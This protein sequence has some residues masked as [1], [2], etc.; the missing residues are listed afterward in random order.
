[1]K[2]EGE[3]AYEPDML[4]LM[5]RF[6]EVLGDDKKVWREAT[7]IKDRS[8]LIDGKT[9]KNPTF[10]NFE[11]VIDVLLLDPSKMQAEEETDSTGLFKTEEDKYEYKRRKEI[12]L[13]EIEGE[14]TKVW[15]STGAGDKQK[16]L[17]ALDAVFGTRSWTAVTA[18]GIDALETG[19][20][21]IRELV[22]DELAKVFPDVAKKQK[23]N[24][25]AK[26]LTKK[27]EDNA[28]AFKEGLK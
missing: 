12:A 23:E 28:K 17:D 18:L 9:F 11:P 24:K 4:V 13:E 14:L 5:E 6:E 19:L 21:G 25:Q 7:V 2:V 1:M 15:P 8:T 26:K 10:A 27:G 20:K 3:T 22:N 16:K